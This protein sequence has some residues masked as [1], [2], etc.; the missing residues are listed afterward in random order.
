MLGLRLDEPLALDAELEPA[1]DAAARE[2]LTDRGLVQSV[3]RPGEW[4]ALTTRGRFLGDAVTAE[5][6]AG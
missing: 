5:L 1:L 4:L 2:R 6:I 3:G